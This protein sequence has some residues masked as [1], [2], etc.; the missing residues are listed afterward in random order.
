MADVVAEAV[1]VVET[2]DVMVVDCDVVALLV[3][4]DVSVVVALVVA[5][6]V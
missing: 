1:P 2:V 4:D 3:C 5:L 6:E